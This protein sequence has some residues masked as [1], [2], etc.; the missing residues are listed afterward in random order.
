MFRTFAAALALLALAACGTEEPAA[1][2]AP[3]PV[4]E[5]PSPAAVPPTAVPPT[6][7]PAPVPAT[8]TAAPT[9][10]DGF[11]VDAAVSGRTLVQLVDP[12]D[13]P[14]FYCVDVPGFG[15]NL[16]LSAAMM[17]HTCKPGADDEIFA[18][19]D[20][21]PG[22]LS[23]PSYGLCLEAG[24]A[25]AMSELFL[26]ECSDS[27]M[28]RFALDEDGA[29]K[30]AGTELCVAVAP[31]EGEPTGGPSH[32]RRDLMLLDCAEAEPVL[33]QWSFPGPSPR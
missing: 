16:R 20:P 23:M 2:S 11:D 27:A 10:P 3:A 33:R 25:E 22:Q 17:A 6:P 14:E 5:T 13:E 15:A 4:A 21:G 19:N 26:R 9:T 18:L 32:V 24:G 31:G 8:A 1:V 28:Q 29:L 30:L 12:L 7:A